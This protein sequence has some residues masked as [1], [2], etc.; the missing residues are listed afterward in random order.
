MQVKSE[1]EE[2]LRRCED[3]PRFSFGR[4]MMK[5]YGD[6]K[7]FSVMYLSCEQSFAIT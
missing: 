5:N 7:G 6:P 1:Y 2:R 3:V 4:R